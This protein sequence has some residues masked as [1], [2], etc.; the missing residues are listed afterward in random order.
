MKY[1]SGQSRSLA[2]K[3]RWLAMIDDRHT[4]DGVNLVSILYA[5]RFSL[6]TSEDS[7]YVA[8]KAGFA[9]LF[10]M[11]ELMHKEKYVGGDD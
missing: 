1:M 11:A 10:R 6:R 5:R 2:R 8:V 7:D 4:N 9:R 3:M